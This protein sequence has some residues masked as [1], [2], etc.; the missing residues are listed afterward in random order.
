M[1]TPRPQ[2]FTDAQRME[3]RSY[4][5]LAGE[6]IA[7]YWP[8]R[9]FIHHNPLHGLESLPFEEAVKR[10]AQLFG[11]RGYLGNETFREYLRQGRISSRDLRAA[12]APLAAD[13]EVMFGERRTTHLDVLI[14]AMSQGV[15]EPSPCGNGTHGKT[16]AGADAEVIEA[17]ALRLATIFPARPAEPLLP[18]PRWDSI[19]LPGRETLSTWC[20]LTLGTTIVETINQ[21]LVKWCSVFLDEGEAGWAMPN[22]DKKFFRAWK[23]LAQYDGVFRCL[24]IKQAGQRIRALPDRTEDAV[25]DSLSTL[26]LPK[27]VWEEYLSLH[28]AA[29]PGWTGYIKWRSNQDNYSWQQQFPIDL[30][31]YLAVRLF[32]ERELVE[33]ALPN[34]PRVRRNVRCDSKIHG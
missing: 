4:V 6:A 5:Q 16:E 31:K 1:S 12:L 8:M 11:G 19:A 32:Y 34:P 26:T 27:P 23:S 24:G 13:K 21:E 3:L 17:V 22:R 29:L 18:P 20:D 15:T 25:L 10:G 2:P 30:V 9:T 28:L 7:Q 33:H 14:A